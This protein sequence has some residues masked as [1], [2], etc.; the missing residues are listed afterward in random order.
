M[1]DRS[2]C[3]ES[4]IVEEELERFIRESTWTNVNEEAKKKCI[5]KAGFQ[6]NAQFDWLRV[7]SSR[8]Q[9]ENP[10]KLF[11]GY[12]TSIMLFFSKV[13]KATLKIE[14][15]YTEGG[16][17]GQGYDDFASVEIEIPGLLEKCRQ[18]PPLW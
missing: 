17:F 6:N 5:D 3:R 16:E 1:S 4:F 7:R 8:Q 14:K 2:D 15:F 18:Q 13:D 10:S 12:T 9:F 11:S